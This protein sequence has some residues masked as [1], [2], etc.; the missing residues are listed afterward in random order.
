MK[1]PE[2]SVKDLRAKS[3]TETRSNSVTLR[4]S[5]TA[6]ECRCTSPSEHER[7]PTTSQQMHRPLLQDVSISYEFFEQSG[8]KEVHSTIGRITVSLRSDR[9]ML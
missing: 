3:V 2:V 7:E 8:A 4:F 5:G 9:V 6:G 1:L